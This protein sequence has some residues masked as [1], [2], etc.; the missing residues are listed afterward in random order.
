M[1]IAKSIWEENMTRQKRNMCTMNGILLN[2]FIM[3]M[4][5]AHWQLNGWVGVSHDGLLG[6]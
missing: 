5:F 3:V 2:K 4:Q 1:A 6:P